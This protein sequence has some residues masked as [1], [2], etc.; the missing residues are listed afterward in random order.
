MVLRPVGGHDLGLLFEMRN[1]PFIAERSLNHRTVSSI[2]HGQWFKALMARKELLA[3][4]VVIDGVPAGHAR[5]DPVG[6][7]WLITLYLVEKFTNKSFGT[8]VISQVCLLC[9]AQ[10]PNAMVVAEIVVNNKAAVAAFQRAGFS[11]DLRDKLNRG[12]ETL[13]WKAVG[14]ES[15]TALHYERLFAVHGDSFQSLD[16]GSYAGQQLRYATLAKLANLDNASILDVGCGLGHFLDWFIKEG[17]N[18][19]YTG[20]DITPSLVVAAKN[21]YPDQPIFLGSILDKNFLKGQQFDYVFA[22]G[23]FYTYVTGSDLVLQKS[24]ENMWQL[25][26]KGLAFNALST[27]APDRVEDEYYADPSNVVSFCRSLTQF[28][29]IA[30]DYHPRDFTIY[31]K[32]P[33]N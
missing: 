9:N 1:D 11:K 12:H 19:Q 27:L 14:E 8:A 4:I 6:D 3:W 10:H 24:V 13:S 28:V 32:R 29:E 17:I 16:W 7:V 23:I 30:E 5:L 2:E 21:R 25:A 31:M 15:T 33:T 18:V 26:K 20:M 22:S